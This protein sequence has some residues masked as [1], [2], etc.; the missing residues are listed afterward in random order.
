MIVRNDILPHS[1]TLPQ[2]H[3]DALLRIGGKTPFGE[4]M[5]RLILAETR[6]TKA[7]GDWSIWDDSVALDDRGG[8]NIKKALQLAQNGATAEQLADALKP[9]TPLRV[10]CG[11]KDVPLYPNEGFIIEKWKPAFSFGPP[12]DWP[13]S[14]GPY[15]QYGDY[16]LLAG[17]TPYLPTIAEC[18]VVIRSNMRSV[19]E[20]PTSRRERLIRL[21]NM[22]QVKLDAEKKR[23]QQMIEDFV[24]DGPV[25]KLRNRLSLGAGRIMSKLALDA[26]LKG[27]WGS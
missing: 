8:L 27:H 26:G 19:E 6:V 10:E 24:K 2:E 20:R 4:P 11:I 22:H 7:S 14:E 12:S 3:K 18:E 15:P 23:R 16:E 21:M 9:A 5:Y 1:Y 17:P 13:S 25:G